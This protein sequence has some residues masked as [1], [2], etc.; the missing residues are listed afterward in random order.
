ML[1]KSYLDIKLFPYRSRRRFRG[2]PRYDLQNVTRGFASRIDDSSEDRVL[3]E[4][5]CAAY[6]KAVDH[7]KTALESYRPTKWWQ[8]QQTR[9]QAVMQALQNRDIP[10]LRQMYSNFYRDPCSSGLIPISGMP[11]AAAD[12]TISD[13]HRH[14]YLGDTLY[15]IDYWTKQTGGRF[16]IADL[17]G[18]YVGNPFG[19]VIDGTLVR[20]EAPYQH[21]CAYRLSTLLEAGPA[22]IAEIGGGFGGMAYFLLRDRPALTYFD[23]D[24]PESIALTSYF[25]MKA[26]P[27]LTFLLYGEKPMMPEEIARA[28][29]VLVPLLAME[30]MQ[31]RSVDVTF[32]SHSISALAPAFMAHYFEIMGRITKSHFLYVG[33]TAAAKTIADLTSQRAVM[34]M[35]STGVSN[36]NGHKSANWNDVEALYRVGER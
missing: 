6:I 31:P 23:F 14:F 36:W 12:G 11:W 16:A 19:V 35:V 18:P 13:T 26:F 17:A 22:T 8:E 15:S 1:A 21:Y 32:S 30:K 28:N 5:I 3:L 9:L 7:Q 34:R 25:L 27:S 24:V 20:F 2:D 10:A 33:A 4:R 29:V